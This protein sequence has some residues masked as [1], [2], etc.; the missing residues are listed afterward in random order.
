VPRD[1]DNYD[2]LQL[3][4]GIGNILS[5]LAVSTAA[6]ASINDKDD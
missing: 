2:T 4:S 1:P 3:V 6:I 5:Q